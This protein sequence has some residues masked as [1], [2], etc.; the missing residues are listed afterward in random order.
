M[1]GGLL[2]NSAGFSFLR[3]ADRDDSRIRHAV[4]SGSWYPGTKEEL[5]STVD[6]YLSQ[7][8]DIDLAGNIIGL[9]APHAGFIYSAP[10]AA[11]AYKPLKGMSFDT[12]VILGNAHREGFIGAA[13]DSARAYANPLGQVDIDQELATQIVDKCKSV[14]LNK[15]PHLQEHSLEIQIPFLQRTLKKGFKILPILF[16]YEPNNADKQLVEALIDVMQT[17]KI[18]LVASTDLTHYPSWSDAKQIDAKTLEYI[19]SMDVEKL[20][21]Y[22]R[23]VRMKG[24]ENLSCALCGLTA[25]GVVMSVSQHLG[26]NN[27]RV[28]KYA[29][30]GDAEIGDRQRVVG[31]GAVAFVKED[32]D[33][34][35]EIETVESNSEKLTK[36]ETDML[37]KMSRNILTS[38]V[39][40]GDIPVIHL[41]NRLENIKRGAFVTLR[42]GE[43]LRGCIGYIEP[44]K[45]CAEA[46]RDNTISA[47][48]KDPR[49][50]PVKASELDD[51]RIEISI[52]TPPEKVD[53]WKDI[54][55]GKHGIVLE[56]GRNRSVFL[57]QVA[58][59]QD[60]DL[61]TTLNYLAQKA[62]LSFEA[63][64]KDTNFKVF[65]AQVFCEE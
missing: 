1:I 5:S 52:L 58:I 23:S 30:S 40:S 34:E 22:D 53:S 39:T 63:W 54:Q 13:I 36:N 12:V 25:T 2:M 37:L 19:A 61:E 41:N 64:K 10:V 38:Y 11:Y 62:G 50:M 21:V 65:E 17:K 45:T 8:E 3:A 20:K 44:I 43:S 33:S 15:K 24:V 14:T 57:P 31:Y 32:V 27:G 7:V 56:K 59:E 46:V 28:L 26:G 55:I 29:N 47:A 48:A 6:T 60:W 9:V 42:K 49:F 16:G 4:Y 51:I 18:L 35:K